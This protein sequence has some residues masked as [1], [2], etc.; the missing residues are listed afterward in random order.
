MK[1]KVILEIANNHMGDVAHGKKII[2]SFYSITKQFKNEIEFI[3]KYQYRDSKTFIHQKSDKQNKFVKRFSETF[4]TDAQWKNLL[5]YTRKYFKTA[6]TPFDEISAKK[7]F[8]QKYDYV[9]IASCS[10]TDWPLVEKIYSLYKKKRKKILI[11]LGGLNDREISRVFSYFNNRKVDFNFL[12]CVAKYPSSD[13]DLN[14]SYFSKLKKIYGDCVKGLS[15]HESADSEITPIIAYGTGVRIFEKHIGIKT[16]KYKIN[17]YSVTPKKLERWLTALS[18]SIKLWGSELKRNKNIANEVTQLNLLKRGVYLKKDVIKNEQIKFRDLYFAFP[19]SD[20]QMKANNLSKNLKIF[21]KFNIKKDSPLKFS[22]I[23]VI[24]KYS[25][26]LKIR[27]RI[28]NFLRNSG[29]I[30]P[31]N[32]RLEISFHY[33]IDSFYKFGL[34]MINVINDKYC[35]KLLILLP[36]Q[37]HPAQYHKI[38]KESFFILHGVVDLKINNKKMKLK[39]GNLYTINPKDV[40]EFSSSNGAIIEELSTTSIKSDSYYLDDKINKNKERKTFIYL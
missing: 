40:H 19:C 27:D 21:S 16:K 13:E 17:N 20:G 36:G 39:S 2:K 28:Q 5:N 37:R 18:N 24:D 9:K 31:K 29:I 35:K 25:K 3:V 8:S 23:K 10:S 30:L 22:K 38:K 33:G 12:F 1:P 15:L 11:S 34:T 32:P 6:C 4:L 7:V 26:V 14:L